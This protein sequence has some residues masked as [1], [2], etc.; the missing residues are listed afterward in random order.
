M[1]RKLET[2]AKDLTAEKAL[3]EKLRD[4]LVLR[5]GVYHDLE[6]E[7]ALHQQNNDLLKTKIED[8]END[9][10]ES[11][12]EVDRYKTSYEDIKKS[13]N[14]LRVAEQF[15]LAILKDFQELNDRMAS[16]PISGDLHNSESEMGD[17]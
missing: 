15:Y 13:Y 3:S 5:K 4:D 2:A 17:L 8:L 11:S 12:R 7:L 14:D 1:E 16:K 10:A 6:S 9:V